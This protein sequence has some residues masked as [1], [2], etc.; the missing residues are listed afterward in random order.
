MARVTLT[1][2]GRRRW[3]GGHPWIYADDVARAEAEPGELVSV[4]APDESVLGFGLY[5]SRSRIAL[6]GVTRGS[7]SP[8]RAFWQA[9][10]RSALE[11]RRM[12][13]LLAPRGAERMLAGDADG[14]PGFVVDRYADVLVVQSGCQGSDRMR[15]TWLELLGSELDLAIGSVLDRSDSATR[16]HEELEPRVEWLR[17][18]SSGQIEV[19]EDARDGTSPLVYE[20]SVL[21]GHKTGHY[22]DQRENR[23]H[24]ARFARDRSVLDAFSYDGLFGIRAALAGAASVLCVDQSQEALERAARNAERNNVAGRVRGARA[25]A[26]HDLRGRAEAGE[27]YDLVIVD[28]PAFA[29]SRR[30]IEGALRGYREL[31]RR[32]MSLLNPGG[33]LV[34]CSCSF[35]VDR[36][37]FLACLA[38]ASLDAGRDARIFRTSGAAADHPV[39]A[40]LPESEY[41]KCAFV[42]VT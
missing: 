20:V 39:L 5:S 10:V 30:E 17:G 21:E 11:L 3:L 29:K 37:S 35:N 8:D 42:R 24:A 19:V 16:A 36:E 22:L 12:H 27:R 40:T 1:G 23:A 33:V 14:F 25:N 15:D 7:E 6:R 9:R 4:H 2:R 32:A 18:E 13:G 41:L 28:P 31:N 26:M 34:T 38:Q